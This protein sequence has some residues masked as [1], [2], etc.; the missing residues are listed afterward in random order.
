MK[1]LFIQNSTLSGSLKGNRFVYAGPEHTPEHQQSVVDPLKQYELPQQQSVDTRLESKTAPAKAEE[2]VKETK[3]TEK[4]WFQAKL[5]KFTE[6]F[7]SKPETAKEAKEQPKSPQEQLKQA[8]EKSPTQET[9]NKM[10]AEIVKKANQEYANFVGSGKE[11]FSN[12]SQE[13]GINYDSAP[14]PTRF[15]RETLKDIIPTSM[16]RAA[17]DQARN[18]KV[19]SKQPE[20]M[21]LTK[22]KN[23]DDLQKIL[24]R[25]TDPKSTL[26]AIS[27]RL[28]E[29]VADIM[30]NDKTLKPEVAFA[31][32]AKN[33][34]ID[35]PV[36]WADTVI[37]P[38]ILR[39]LKIEDT[40]ASI[41]DTAIASAQKIPATR[42]PAVAPAQEQMLAQKAPARAPEAK[43]AETQVASIKTPARA[44]GVATRKGTLGGAAVASRRDE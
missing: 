36:V 33:L 43:P 31:A 27:I 9:A 16:L 15:A 19:P 17:I 25:S 30:K 21:L 29:Q 34:G 35:T 4:S 28:K 13:Y 32:F 38:R 10:T 44:P 2:N 40:Y 42:R 8:F 5:E 6:R 22:A 3:T 20:E 1:E 24:N 41:L 26:E 12:L 11:I 39:N 18:E 23:L 14:L 7:K 37:V